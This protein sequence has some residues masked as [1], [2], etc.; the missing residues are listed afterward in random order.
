MHISWTQGDVIINGLDSYKEAKVIENCLLDKGYVWTY[1][2]LEINGDY[3]KV[4]SKDGS[5]V[6]FNNIG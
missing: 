6:T 5:E 3:I 4:L 2:N 1:K